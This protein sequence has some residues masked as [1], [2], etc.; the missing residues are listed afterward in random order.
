MTTSEITPAPLPLLSQIRKF[1]NVVKSG[2]NE[3]QVRKAQGTDYDSIINIMENPEDILDGMDHLPNFLS[4][5]LIEAE[6][7]NKNRDNFVLSFKEEIIGFWTIN[8][9]KHRTSCHGHAL[10]LN[11][12]YRGKYGFGNYFGNMVAATLYKEN[13]NLQ[14]AL[15]SLRTSV[16]FSDSYYSHPK[17]DILL[18]KKQ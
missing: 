10:R 8:F 7:G 2:E 15:Y 13:P 3:L 5:F 14:T 1:T 4:R 11:P 9:I 12:K 16:D 18:I 17:N 6:E